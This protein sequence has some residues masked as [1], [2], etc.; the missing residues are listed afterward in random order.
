MK[1]NISFVFCLFLTCVGGICAQ[2]SCSH[3]TVRLHRL[4]DVYNQLDKEHCWNV[5]VDDHESWMWWTIDTLNRINNIFDP[6]FP[7]YHVR[8]N[9]SPLRKKKTG[10]IRPFREEKHILVLS[11]AFEN[12][13]DFDVAGDIYEHLIIDSMR[14]VNAL[15]IDKYNVI[16]GVTDVYE[17]GDYLELETRK[18]WKCHHNYSIHPNYLRKMKQIQPDLLLFC[19]DLQYYQRL[20]FVKNNSIYLVDFDERVVALEDAVKEHSS[21]ILKMIKPKRYFVRKEVEDKFKKGI[22]CMGEGC[23]CSNRKDNPYQPKIEQEWEKYLPAVIEVGKTPRD[24]VR[25]ID[26]K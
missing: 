16:K 23:M 18:K 1:K 14:V 21:S 19:Q 26:P 4:F 24:M 5:I 22:P 11:V 20:M 6:I 7:L 10:N 12:I 9:K 8:T 13:T 17:R 25:I 15:C 2:S 3:D